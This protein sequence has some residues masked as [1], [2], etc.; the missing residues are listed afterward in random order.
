MVWLTKL[1]MADCWWM[2]LH[3][4]TCIVS[5]ETVGSLQQWEK[6]LVAMETTLH[7]WQW[8][9]RP[10]L[11]QV[12]QW[13]FLTV[14]SSDQIWYQAQAMCSPDKKNKTFMTSSQILLLFWLTE[15]DEVQKTINKVLRQGVKNHKLNSQ[16]KQKHPLLQQL[17]W[18]QRPMTDTSQTNAKRKWQTTAAS[19]P[20][21]NQN[22][23]SNGVL[24][25]FLLNQ[26]AEGREFRGRRW[27]TRMSW[28]IW[29][30]D[31]SVC[32]TERC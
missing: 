16:R 3:E 20:I 18:Q 8:M 26:S 7:M 28:S 13:Q 25:R 11:T 14:I 30:N 32:H 24:C 12:V 5:M 2:S 6:M 27:G 15:T 31:K 1:L 9:G 23:A 4:D 10:S 21:V 22:Q 29:S 17:C 19:H